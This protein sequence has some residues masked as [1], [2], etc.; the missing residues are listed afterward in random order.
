MPT[1]GWTQKRCPGCGR[2]ETFPF[3]EKDKVCADCQKYIEAGRQL[4]KAQDDAGLHPILVQGTLRLCPATAMSEDIPSAERV[5][6][7]LE[8]LAR[9]D[10]L[11]HVATGRGVAKMLWEHYNT[12]VHDAALALSHEKVKL[13]RHAAKTISQFGEECY[14]AGVADG[15]DM[16][17]RLRR[18]EITF[19]RFVS[20]SDGDADAVDDDS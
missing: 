15:S 9:L 17:E 19:D 10:A 16:L 18:G 13:L 12:S 11:P 6:E 5:Q 7:A 8:A 1:P 3:R 4:E 2:S 20:D 14:R